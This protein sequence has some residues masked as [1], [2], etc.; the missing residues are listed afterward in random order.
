MRGAYLRLGVHGP[1]WPSLSRELIPEEHFQDLWEEDAPNSPATPPA[2]PSAKPDLLNIT[3]MD[4]PSQERSR[5]SGLAVVESELETQLGWP[6]G[7]PSLT[8][9]SV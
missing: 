6:E 4:M 7:A 8:F 3:G 2:L 9:K 5:V 1:L